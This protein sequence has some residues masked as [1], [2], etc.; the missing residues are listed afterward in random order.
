MTIELNH[1][2]V[3]ARDKQKSASFLAGILGLPVGKP[4]GPFLPVAVGPVALDYL[5]DLDEFTPQHHAFLVDDD[6]FDAALARL[7][8]Q[9]VQIWADPH[10]HEPDTINHH[11]GGRGV[12][13]QDPDGHLMEL[14]TSPYGAEPA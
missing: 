13:F 11:Y 8:D 9:R 1:T 14:I 2:I 4:W 6:A 3:H 10:G 12:Y 7:A 5:D